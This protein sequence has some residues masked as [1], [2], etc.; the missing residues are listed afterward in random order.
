MS[1]AKK[2][3]KA[4]RLVSEIMA[5]RDNFNAVT[6]LWSHLLT[7]I[8]KTEG[9][10]AVIPLGS[11]DV[12]H[13]CSL[14]EMLDDHVEAARFFLGVRNSR[15]DRRWTTVVLELLHERAREIALDG[16]GT[17]AMVARHGDGHPDFMERLA[18]LPRGR[19]APKAQ[20]VGGAGHRAFLASRGWELERRDGGAVIVRKC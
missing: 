12:M 3:G 17:F 13:I 18:C 16:R 2:P 5:V 7:Q 4:E 10:E 14:N 9:E 8:S 15:T 20:G 6:G 1:V 11:G 19:S